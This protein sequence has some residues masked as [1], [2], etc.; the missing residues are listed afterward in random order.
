M[1]IHSI[2]ETTI[3]FVDVYDTD[4]HG[5][6]VLCEYIRF[7]ENNWMMRFGEAY[8]PILHAEEKKLEDMFRELQNSERN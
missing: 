1:K 8:E 3:H 5:D 7:S 6:E 4:I 2:D